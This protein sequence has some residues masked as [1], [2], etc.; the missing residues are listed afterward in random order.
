MKFLLV[1]L[2]LLSC[3][4]K[5]YS[6]T[7]FFKYKEKAKKAYI[8]RSSVD[9]VNLGYFA[10][11]YI[12]KNYGKNGISYV[13]SEFNRGINRSQS[14]TSYRRGSFVVSDMPFSIKGNSKFSN[15][16]ETYIPIDFQELFK[17][18]DDFKGYDYI[19]CF[20]NLF[21]AEKT[22]S[23]SGKKNFADASIFSDRSSL[24]SEHRG[25]N[26]AD[27]ISVKGVSVYIHYSIIDIKTN[28]IL[29]HGFVDDT[30]YSKIDFRDFGKY[31]INKIIDN[32]L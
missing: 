29:Q 27:G 21:V 17:L 18:N 22:N 4:T 13:L 25:D 30:F 1:L 8:L 12:E 31:V 19:I 5:K 20:G 7:S 16:T 2:L 32:F 28:M 24:L 14:N 26:K 10:N 3:T 23:V 11:K 6:E 15:Y 9:S